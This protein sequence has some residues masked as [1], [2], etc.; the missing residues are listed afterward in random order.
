MRLKRSNCRSTG[1]GVRLHGILEKPAIRARPIR[2]E[3]VLGR[4]LRLVE[5]LP[6]EGHPPPEGGQREEADRGHLAEE[7]ATSRLCRSAPELH[8]RGLREERVETQSGTAA[9]KEAL[10]EPPT[11]A[12]TRTLGLGQINQGKPRTARCR[13]EAVPA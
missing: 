7:P 4:T 1:D 6:T 9:K 8:T 10:A 2:E 12:E 13:Q 11:R 5:R 3:D